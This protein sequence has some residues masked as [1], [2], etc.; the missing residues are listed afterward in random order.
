MNLILLFILYF[1]FI[2]FLNSIFL[3]K[4]ILIDKKI[5]DHKSFISKD[6]VP[7]SGGFLIIINLLIFNSNYLTN[8]FFLGIFSLGVFSDLMIIQNPV[9][10]FLI[11]LLIVIFF[12]LLFNISILST[13]IFFVDFFIQNKLLALLF[14]AFCFLILINGSNFLDGINTLVCGYY[15]LIVL[16]I[17]YIGHYNKINYNFSEFNYLL[18]SLLV[19]FLFNIFSKCYLGD[20]GTFLLSFFI[21]YHLINLCNINLTLNKFISPAF[22]ML[23]LW[24]PAFENLFSII[25]KILTNKNASDPDN[26]HFHHLLFSYLNKKIN[27]KKTVNSL[28]GIVINFYNFLIFS[29]S[30]SFYNKTNFLFFLVMINVCVYVFFYLILYKKEFINQNK[31]L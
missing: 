7:I 23:L 22:I 8:I 13:K 9:K 5:L 31:V 18:I 4:K 20:S 25:R 16:V 27:N 29:I 21:G 24:Y 12:L 10:K 17:L 26:F 3:K 2:F 1:F 30:L 14:T 6:L 19:I 11:Q 28:T 15:I